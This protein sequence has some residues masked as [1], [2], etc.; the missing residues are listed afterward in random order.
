MKRSKFSSPT[1]R[2]GRNRGETGV[3]EPGSIGGGKQERKGREEG[4][5]RRDSFIKR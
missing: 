3:R 4:L 5:R 1:M 2:E